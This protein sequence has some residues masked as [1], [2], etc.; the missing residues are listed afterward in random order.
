MGILVDR[1]FAEHVYMILKEDS[2][3]TDAIYEDYILYM[4]GN[5]GLFALKDYKLVETCGIV[6]GRQLYALVDLTVESRE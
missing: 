4:V 3:G 1:M 6:N 5:V 2:K